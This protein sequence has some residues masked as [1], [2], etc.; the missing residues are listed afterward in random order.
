MLSR[1]Q[2]KARLKLLGWSYRRIAPALD[3]THVH[4]AKVLSGERESRRI[5]RLIAKLP[6]CPRDQ[7]P[8]NSPLRKKRAA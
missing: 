6:A 4:L 7:I 8:H 5:M 3:V 1:Q 2:A